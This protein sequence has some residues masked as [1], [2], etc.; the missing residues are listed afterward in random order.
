MEAAEL[1]QML[2]KWIG[3]VKDRLAALEAGTQTKSAKPSSEPSPKPTEAS[4]ALHGLCQDQECKAC[5]EQAQ[6][7]VDGAYAKGQADALD[8]YDRWLLMAGGEDFRQK[9]LAAAVRGKQ[10]CD[11]EDL[12]AMDP[13]SRAN[14]CRSGGEHH[15]RAL[16]RSAAQSQ[17]RSSALC[18]H[19]CA[20]G[21]RL[22]TSRAEPAG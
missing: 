4:Q 11:Q 2:Q 3:P 20:G 22:S 12:F 18:R 7:L 14:C 9:I 6:E 13:C 5:V 15:D 21:Y 1:D 10:L 17:F 19:G 8:S 16:Q